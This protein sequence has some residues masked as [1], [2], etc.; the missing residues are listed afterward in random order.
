MTQSTLEATVFVSVTLCV[1]VT[2]W[3]LSQ[4]TTISFVWGTTP[5]FVVF[6][7]SDSKSYRVQGQCGVP[8]AVQAHNPVMPNHVQG[9]LFRSI[10]CGHSHVCAITSDFKVFA[11]GGNQLLQV[12]MCVRE[13]GMSV[14]CVNVSVCRWYVYVYMCVWNVLLTVFIPS[15]SFP[16]APPSLPLIEAR[17]WYPIQPWTCSGPIVAQTSVTHCLWPRYHLYVHDGSRI[18]QHGMVSLQ[19]WFFVYFSNTKTALSNNY[20]QAGVG[21]DATKFGEPKNIACFNGKHITLHSKYQHVLVIPCTYILWV[22]AFSTWTSFVT[23]S[24]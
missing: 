22:L 9:Y 2:L 13:C 7:L 15:L 6:S 8:T 14:V 19:L 21:S 3:L 10:S 20:R 23:P 4:G 16:P 12:C 1:A 18:V 11:W 17:H 5:M 24:L